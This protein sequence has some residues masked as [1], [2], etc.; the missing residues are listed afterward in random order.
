MCW[1]P[2]NFVEG[3][4]FVLKIFAITMLYACFLWL[5]MQCGRSPMSSELAD[6][7]T[8]LNLILHVGTTAHI[9]FDLIQL[10]SLDE[11]CATEM[12]YSHDH[13]GGYG[14]AFP[15]IQTTLQ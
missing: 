2:I 3:T 9:P 12:C 14:S 4:F 10:I 5:L 7:C 15:K 1:L 6:P 13:T 11:K 8:I